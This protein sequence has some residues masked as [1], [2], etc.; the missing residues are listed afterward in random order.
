MDSGPG[1]ARDE[2]PDGAARA[3]RAGT[4]GR[5]APH[6]ALRRESGHLADALIR[7]LHAESDRARL[8]PTDFQCHLL[9]RL[10]GPMTPGE[11]AENLRLAAGSV[12]GVIDRLEA[13]GLARR[14]QH[15]DDRRKIIVRAEGET[16]TRGA[17]G[18][19]GI[20][21]GMTALHEHYSETEL[22]IL[23]D[24][25][26]RVGTALHDAASAARR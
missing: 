15:P 13:R 11:I 21:E 18:E 3:E 19:P 26:D 14:E 24:W 17:G 25:L 2:R 6:A 4:P 16:E 20:R 9:L 23:V 8:N 10:T 1:A 12:T 5:D 22:E 7:L